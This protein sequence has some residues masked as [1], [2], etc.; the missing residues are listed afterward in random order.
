M[1]EAFGSGGQSPEDPIKSWLPGAFLG[2]EGKGQ[3]EF[4]MEACLSV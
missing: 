1:A 2:S 4:G 3:V